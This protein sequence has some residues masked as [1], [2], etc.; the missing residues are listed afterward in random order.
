MSHEFHERLRGRFRGMLHWSDLDAL[1]AVVRAQPEGWYISMLGEE[2][3]Q[4]PMAAEA[5]NEFI[6]E[7]DALLRREHDC[8]HCG[9]VYADDIVE[10]TLIKIHDPANIGSSCSSTPVPP[11]WML[12]RMQP[13]L[14]VDETP[15][16]A[17][18]RRWWQRFFN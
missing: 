4:Q 8:T 12:S 14:V 9:I 6:T 15:L 2:P 13:T 1:W 5:L 11:R 16:P 17:N 3:A 10:P 7:V 18:R